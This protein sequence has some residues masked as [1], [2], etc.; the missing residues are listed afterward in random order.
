MRNR[1][2]WTMPIIMLAILVGGAIKTYAGTSESGRG[3]LWGGSDSPATFGWVSVNNVDQT[4]AVVN[5][6]VPYGLNIVSPGNVTGYAWSEN[7]GWISFNGADL[8][9]TV[10]CSPV[11]SQAALSLNKIT[12]GARILS[13]K[14]DAEKVPSNSGGWTGCISLS[15]TAA[16]GSSYGVTLDTATGTFGGYAWSDEIGWIDFSGMTIASVNGSCGNSGLPAPGKSYAITDSAYPP[17]GTFCDGAQPSTTPTFPSPGSPTS[18][19]CQGS[20]IGTSET[21]TAQRECASGSTWDASTSACICQDDWTPVDTSNV[22]SSS[23]LIQ[24][25]SNCGGPLKQRIINGTKNCSLD[26]WQEVAPE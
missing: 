11:L 6:A 15:G 8:G 5:G 13:I 16:D 9:G 12:G 24:E 10:S 18:W 3:W 2:L 22:C 25:A 17:A 19:V 14:T 1:L 23:T 20:G 26:G 21:C 4:G 7:Y